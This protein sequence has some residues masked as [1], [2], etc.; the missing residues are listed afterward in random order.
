M[1]RY[2]GH[3]KGPWKLINGVQ[4]R[5]DRDQIA[6]VWM[7]RE[8]EGSANARL[9]ADAPQLYAA[10]VAI[11]EGD[12]CPRALARQILGYDEHEGCGCE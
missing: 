6:K 5:S 4:V 10:L 3:T 7:M 11:A 8:G 1:D 12:G 2:E 9:I